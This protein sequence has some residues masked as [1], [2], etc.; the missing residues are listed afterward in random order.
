MGLLMH[1][2]TPPER[3]LVQMSRCLWAHPHPHATTRTPLAFALLS[4][5]PPWLVFTY[6]DLHIRF[7]YPPA[8]GLEVPKHHLPL[9]MFPPTTPD[10]CHEYAQL[11]IHGRPQAFPGVRPAFGLQKP[12]CWGRK[13]RAF[14]VKI[15]T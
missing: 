2:Q 5:L 13:S 1:I 6:L 11:Q 7:T 3:M 9:L 14:E 15:W 12:V 4:D 8:R 10:V